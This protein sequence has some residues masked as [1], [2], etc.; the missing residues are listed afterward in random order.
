MGLYA[1]FIYMHKTSYGEYLLQNLSVTLLLAGST[2]FTG[3]LSAIL[4]FGS[5]LRAA[6]APYLTARWSVSQ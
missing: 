3:K 6:T 5:G 1:I 4:M 2:F